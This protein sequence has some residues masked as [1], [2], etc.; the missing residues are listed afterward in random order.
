MFGE[1]MNRYFEAPALIKM[2]EGTSIFLAGGITDCPDWQKPTAERLTSETDLI[3]FNPRRKK[4][5]V[6]KKD[7][8]SVKQIHW[9]HTYLGQVDIVMFW[10]PKES[11]CP[12][13]LLELGKFLMKPNTQLYVG[14]DPEYPRRLDVEVQ[15]KLERPNVKVWDSLGDMIDIIISDNQL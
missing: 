11:V 13:T 3:V 12:I 4:F 14:T 1:K 8:E 15:T 2:P 9:E 7:K 5:D 10:F 6:S